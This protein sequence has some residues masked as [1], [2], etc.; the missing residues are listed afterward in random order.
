MLQ[1]VP[2]YRG[3][4][5][6][7]T[8]WA[9]ATPA[10][11]WPRLVASRLRAS[12]TSRGRARSE[13]NLVLAALDALPRRVPRSSEE[14]ARAPW[15]PARRAQTR[16]RR[17]LPPG[18]R[19]LLRLARLRP[20][21]PRRPLGG[22]R[23]GLRLGLRLGHEDMVLVHGIE[24]PAVVENDDVSPCGSRC[25]R[26]IGMCAVL[27]VEVRLEVGHGEPGVTMTHCCLYLVRVRVRVRVWV[28]VRVRVRARARVRVRVKV[29]V[30]VR[31]R[32]RV[33]VSV[34][35]T[36]RPGARTS[37]PARAAACASRGRSGRAGGARS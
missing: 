9:R 33:R 4:L 6:R 15:Q 30:R 28:R 34:R 8:P 17:R 14:E 35:V 12:G 10:A 25:R 29:R 13:A 11:R 23:L 36:S 5:R 1:L 20:R 26:L 18:S 21:Q 37:C 27:M 32:V 2:S 24:R 31:G 19:L 22:F 3:F 16:W 7:T